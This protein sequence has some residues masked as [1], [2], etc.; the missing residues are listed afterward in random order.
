MKNLPDYLK[1]KIPK[2]ENIDKIRAL[3]SDDSIHSVCESARCPNIGEC[4]MKKTLTFMIL[5]DCCTRNCGFCGVA[6]GSP[7]PIDPDEPA[8]VVRA[9]LKLG[10]NYVVIT[11]VTRD[12]LADGGAAQF[13]K[14]IKALKEKK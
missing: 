6:K 14:V 2:K 12:D 4:F 11:S 8:K 3:L 7:L 10:L 1:K 13:V 5:G 9:S